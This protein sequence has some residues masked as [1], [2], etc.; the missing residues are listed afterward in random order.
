MQEQEILALSESQVEKIERV[1]AALAERENAEAAK[2][3]EKKLRVLFERTAREALPFI[4]YVIYVSAMSLSAL[5]QIASYDGAKL[6][7]LSA[8]L[9]IAMGLPVLVLPR[10][11]IWWL[12]DSVPRPAPE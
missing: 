7:L 5:F 12:K 3:S 9:V 10:Q 6:W 11:S 8:I 4:V 2:E 1:N